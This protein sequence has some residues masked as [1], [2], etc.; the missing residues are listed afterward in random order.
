MN[1]NE[2]NLL[3]SF[4]NGKYIINEL[5]INNNNYEFYTTSIQILNSLNI[6]P[7]HYDEIVN[8]ISQSEYIN[9]YLDLMKSIKT[10]KLYKSYIHDINHNIKVSIFAL[11]ISIYENIPLD[12]FK[13]IIE[14]SKYHDIGRN[15]DNEDKE[16]GLIS[17]KNIDFLKEVYSD[18][19]LNYLKTIIQCHSLN[20][21]LF[22][23]IAK[24]NKISD[25]ERCRGMFKV[26]KDSDGLD[27]TRLEYP[28]IKIELLRTETSKRLIP[29]SYELNENYKNNLEVNSNE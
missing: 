22:D 25:I 6:I 18:E 3:N 10:D 20:D 16:H 21:E 12:D 5:T 15:G 7:L 29:F 8:K 11:I 19:E 24:E 28:Y 9:T 17:S 27:R 1:Q 13:L 14:A 26:L 23:D 2:L 4:L